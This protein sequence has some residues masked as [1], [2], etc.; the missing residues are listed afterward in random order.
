MTRD[1]NPPA[2]PVQDD[3]PPGAPDPVEHVRETVGGSD[4]RGLSSLKV[5]D[6]GPG[7]A[8]LINPFFIFR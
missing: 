2:L 1:S 5:L 3:D 8:D 7:Q 6:H 4:I